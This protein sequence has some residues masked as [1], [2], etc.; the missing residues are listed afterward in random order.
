MDVVFQK[1]KD[2]KNNKIKQWFQEKFAFLKNPQSLFYYFLFLLFVGLLFFITILVVNMFTTPFSGDYCAQQFSFYTNG[3]DDWW[4]FLRTGE[5]VLYDTNTYLGVNNIGSN[6]FY[7][8]FDPFFLPI[9]LVPRQLVPQGMAVLTIFKMAFGG[10]AFYGYMRYLKV[11]KASSKISGLA[12]AFCGW[13]TWYLWFNHF[14]EIII[15]FPLILWG[16]EKVLNEKKP[17]LLMGSLFLMGVTNFFFLI[18]FAICAFI[19]AMFRFFQKI[20]TRTVK[21]NFEILGIGFIGFLSGLMMS[22]VVVLPAAMVAIGSDRAENST[23]LDNLINAF[24]DGEIE[25]ALNFLFSWK[26]IDSRRE[27]RAAYPLIDFFFPVMSDRGTPLTKLG[28]ETYDNVAGSIFCYTPIIILFVPAL[29]YSIKNKQYSPLIATFAFILML[30]TPFCYYMFH[31]FTVAYS[32]W[33]LFVMTSL[34]AYVGKYLDNMKQQPKWTIV[35]GYI[36]CLVG[37]ICASIAAYL[38]V[39]LNSS[40]TERVPIVGAAIVYAVYVSIVA[41][42]I[43]VYI[44]R[45]FIHNLL[46][47]IIVVEA[48]AMGAFTIYGHGYT[49]YSTVNNGLDENNALASLVKE[50]QKDDPTYYRAY[51][52]LANDSARNDGMRNGYN[53]TSFFHSIYNFN[54]SNFLNWSR[55]TQ[56]LGGWS[57]SY[58]EKRQ[59]LDTFLGVKYYFVEKSD[60]PTDE[61]ADI[62]VNVP[63]DF[64]DVSDQYPSD[65]YYVFKNSNFIDFAFSYD[66]IVAYNS[67]DNPNYSL[68]SGSTYTL[69][70]EDMYLKYGIL[71]YED[72]NELIEMSGGD[73]V[74]EEVYNTFSSKAS[75]TQLPVANYAQGTSSEYVRYYFST[76]QSASTMPIDELALYLKNE[77]PIEYP[78]ADGGG[79]CV[80]FIARQDGQNFPY[81]ENGVIFYLN[82]SF[83]NSHK[84]NAYLLDKN[85]HI[86]TY[87]NHNDDKT[88]STQKSMRGLYSRPIKENGALIKAAPQVKAVMIVP[89]Y[90]GINTYTLYYETYSTYYNDKISNL[91]QFPIENIEYSTN[92]FTFTTNFEKQ[93]F[94]VTQIAF[95]DGWRVFCTDAEGN[96][97]ELKTYL[98]QGGF[99]GF[100]SEEGDCQYVMEYYTPYLELGSYISIGGMFIFFTS[101]VSYYY[102][103]AAFLIK[104]D[105]KKY[106][107]FQNE[108]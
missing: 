27:Y 35:V 97:K 100:L 104:N 12:Y 47:G 77:E 29:I 81:D 26:N 106:N 19:Y 70:N 42:L 68:T 58:V 75:Y 30:V 13:V 37:G 92:K 22:L 46:T 79:K 91:M 21:E 44:D 49:L 63:L 25:R 51:S 9:L 4:H 16:V 6:A 5:F 59:N 34:I 24:K 10:L 18:C 71:D 43:F 107:Q 38:I 108:N 76:P 61:V 45:T 105:I 53:G 1:D 20:K 28:N 64:E 67:A 40:M 89:R 60:I 2:S 87:D 52:S 95:D 78:G 11:S 90:Y 62:M 83:R 54:L 36:F 14:T 65:Y 93:R 98:S 73:I 17:F 82:S 56:N 48:C 39:E 80:V 23:Y 84:I 50:I 72:V 55:M 96:K 41:A 32:R 69:R 33:T 57:G 86:I 74:E 66:K 3:Y 99:V 7:Y 103:A 101:F 94:I 15:V 102:I 85:Y 88:T 31:G 8:L